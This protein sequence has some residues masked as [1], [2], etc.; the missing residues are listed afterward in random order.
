M[1]LAI[2]LYNHHGIVMSADR[3]VNATIEGKEF[4]Q[5]FTEQKLFLVDGKYGLSYTGTASINN[6]PTSALIKNYLKENQ[7]YNSAPEDYLLKT[8]IHFHSIQSEGQNII[9]IMCGY[10][11]SKRF[12]ISTNTI[13]PKIKS[14]P[15]DTNSITYSGQND[16][17]KMLTEQD[18]TIVF[19]YGNFTIQDSID[20]LRFLNKTVHGLM[21][22]G[23][24]FPTVS[25]NCDILAIYPNKS[26]WVE[27]LTPH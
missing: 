11:C 6:V 8:A 14:V 13:S 4:H 25:E 18:Q 3:L 7:S 15:C 26:R 16:F 10:F 21:R 19:D 17:V 2:A 22:F 5:S 1:S 27:R 20:F 24:I 23:Q 12:V 9:F